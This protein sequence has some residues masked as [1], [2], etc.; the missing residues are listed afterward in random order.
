MKR[1]VLGSIKL[2][3]Y[4]KVL[5]EIDIKLASV[6]STVYLKSLHHEFE[7]VKLPIAILTL[8]R[9]GLSFKTVVFH[10]VSLGFVIVFASLSQPYI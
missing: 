5:T 3:A 9:V 1:K 8:G 4:V 2:V 10:A 7:Y 6:P